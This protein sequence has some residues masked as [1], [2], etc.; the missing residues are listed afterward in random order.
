MAP[1]VSPT[2]S[3]PRSLARLPAASTVASVRRGDTTVVGV[4]PAELLVASGPDA[5]ARPRRARPGVLDRVVLVR[6]RPQPRAGATPGGVGGAGDGARCRVRPVRGGGGGGGRRGGAGARRWRRPG[7]ARGRHE[8]ARRRRRRRRGAAAPAVAG[9]RAWTAT[10][11]GFASTRCSS[12]SAPASATRSTS[13]GGSRVTTR[14]DPVALYGALARHHPAP[15]TAMV[16]IPDLGDGVAVVSASPERYLRLRGAHVE[17]RP[18]KGTAA[19]RAALRDQRQGPRRER[20]DRRPRPQRPRARVRPGLDARA[21]VVLGRSAPWPAPPREHRTWSAAPG[22]RGGRARSARPSRRPRSP[23]RPSRASSQA[24]EELEPVRRGVY[25][26]AFGWIDTRADDPA[27]VEADLAVAIRTFTMLG[28][29]S[30]GST[31]FGVGGG[32]VA[33]SRPRRGVGGDRAQG[34]AAA[35][36]RGRRRRRPL[37]ALVSTTLQVLARRR[38]RRRRRRARSRRSTTVCSS[39]T[40]CSRPC[41]CTAAGRS[42]GRR[43]LDRLEHSAAGLGLPVPDR[44]ELRPRPTPCS[45]PTVMPRRGCASPSPAASR[46]WARSVGDVGP[47]RHRRQQRGHAVAGL[48]ARRGRALGTQRARRHRGAQDHLLRGERARARLRARARRERGDLRE[49]PRRAVRGDRLQ[50]VRRARRCDRDTT[51]L[52]GLPARGDPRL[53]A[54]SSAPR[55]R[56]PRSPSARCATPTR[57]SSRRRPARCSPS[58]RSTATSSPVP[59]ARSPRALAAAFAAL[60]ARDLDP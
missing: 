29:G 36:A 18:I 51:R 13:L 54:A 21:L 39:A 2:R 26:G 38:P 30:E 10:P 34:G 24:I 7:P 27:R 52:V 33:D 50:R 31:Q 60:V 28:A 59:P 58:A 9:S 49:H 11:I 42:R 48:G 23:A 45:A 44:E 12:C 47:D 55:S 16:R 20:D 53:G 37:G 40:A 4:E 41:A 43:H 19:T 25:C 14:L 3:P 8:R 46:R 1:C 17:T 56:R 35:C 6:A 15:H 32:I 22:D 57:R 5:M